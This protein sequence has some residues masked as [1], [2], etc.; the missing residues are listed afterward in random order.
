MISRLAFLVLSAV[1]WGVCGVYVAAC[2]LCCPLV[3]MLTA[4][5]YWPE[6]R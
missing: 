3:L 1:A 4:R 2:L 6:W 5:D